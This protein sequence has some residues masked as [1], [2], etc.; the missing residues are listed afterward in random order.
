VVGKRQFV[1]DKAKGWDSESSKKFKSL[2]GE[3]ILN[4]ATNRTNQAVIDDGADDHLK[5]LQ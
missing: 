4:E 2:G 3:A 5:I 1:L